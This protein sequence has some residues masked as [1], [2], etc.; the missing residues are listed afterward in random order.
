MS[1]CPGMHWKSLVGWVLLVLGALGLLRLLAHVQANSYA[2]GNLT[3]GILF[4]LIGV[5]L[6]R[7]GRPGLRN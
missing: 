1:R 3:G 6:I 7:S 4:V 5:W 2:V